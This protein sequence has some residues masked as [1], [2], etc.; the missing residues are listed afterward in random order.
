MD[1]PVTISAADIAW[2]AA[3]ASVKSAGGPSGLTA[4][5]LRDPLL[6]DTALQAL[7]ASV[8]T[9]IVNGAGDDAQIG[10]V[11]SL[12]RLIALLKDNGGVRPIAI[13][14]ILRRLCGRILLRKH[15]QA[16]RETLEPIQ[17]GVGTKNGGIAIVHSA[18]ALLAAK[19]HLVLITIDLVNAFNRMSRVAMFQ[20]LRAAG[21]RLRDVI[22]FVRLFYL[23][24]GKMFVRGRGTGATPHVVESKTGS[25]QGCTFGRQPALER[26]VARRARGFRRAQRLH[27][28]LHRRRDLRRRARRRRRLPRLRLRRRRRPRGGAQL[29]QVRRVQPRV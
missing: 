5:H 6:H 27:R 18:T 15:S 25:Q 11:L 14:E 9:R 2:A 3:T 21:S 24:P 19:P 26:R 17:V 7:L 10:E 22:P 4:A 13:G 1:A 16:A 28:L 29:R 8:F 20:R 23:Q 12:C